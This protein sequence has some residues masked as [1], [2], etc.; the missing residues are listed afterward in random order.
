MRVGRQSHAQNK[1]MLLWKISMVINP[2][3]LFSRNAVLDT[4]FF[5]SKGF[6]FRN[7]EMLSLS[8]LGAS[9]AIQILIVD[10]TLREVEINMRE[11]AQRQGSFMPESSQEQPNLLKVDAYEQR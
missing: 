9:G 2:H 1:F 4:S 3:I 11:S 10:L 7:E 5:I 6:N 8:K